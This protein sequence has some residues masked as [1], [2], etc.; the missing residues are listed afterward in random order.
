MK[1]FIFAITVG[2]ITVTFSMGANAQILN[3]LKKKAQDAAQQKAE[4][5]LA[6][7]VQKMAEQ[8]VEKSWDSIFGEIEDDSLP[9]LK[10]PFSA[11]SNVKTEDE[12]TFDTITTMEIESIPKDGDPEPPV[13]MDMHFNKNE[14]YTGTKFTSEEM[15]K[16][17]GN[18]FIIYDFKNSAMLMLMSNDQEKFSFAYDWKQALDESEELAENQPEEEV[19]WD[20]IEEWH[21]YKKIGSKNILGYDCEGYRSENENQIIDIWVSR[22][23][24]FGMY[25]LFQANTNAKH[26]KGKIPAEYPQGMIMEMITEDLENGDKTKMRVT[27]IK[28]NARV[29]YIMADYPAMSFNPK[30]SK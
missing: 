19:N 27:D 18:V 6:E 23:A 3:R 21:N 14:M 2:L 16:E 25:N 7:Q 17:A 1:Y 24:D 10:L 8:M 22:E 12:Y 5:K 9:G 30:A 13:I 26:L 29:R 15:K 11:N 4:E 28:E 20:E